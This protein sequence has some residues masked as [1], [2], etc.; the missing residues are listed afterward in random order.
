M[1][2]Q[3]NDGKAGRSRLQRI[4]VVLAGIIVGQSI[5]Y[6]PSLIG[7]K[8]LLPL[9]ILAQQDVYIPRTPEIA[10][11]EAQNPTLTDMVYV[12][13]PNRHFTWSELRAGR[14]PMWAP[15]Q[16]GGVP[17]IWPKFSPFLLLQSLTSSPV[18]LAWGQLLAALVAGVGA[19][20]FFSRVLKVSFWPAAFGAWCYPL[21]G[22]FVFWLG[23]PTSLPVCWLPWL[24]LAV[25]YVAHA[26]H[27]LAPL[28]L[29]IATGL[30]LVSGFPDVAGQVL[31]G[32]GLYGLLQCVGSDRDA[33]FNRKVPIALARLACGWALGFLLAAPYLLPVVDYS[34]TGSRM[35]KRGG[36]HEERP[37]IGLAVVPQVVLPDMYGAT[38][39][40]TIRI[41]TDH[42]AESTAA[43]YAGILTTLLLAPLAFCSRTHRRFNV[44]W[45]LLGLFAL[46]WCANVPGF[47]QLFRLPGLNMMSHNRLV[48]LAS[49]AIISLA[50]V[51]LDVLVQGAFEWRRWQWVPVGMAGLLFL[52]SLFRVLSLPEPLTVLLPKVILSGKS[53]S[54]VQDL[55]GMRQVQNWFIR[56][57]SLCAVWCGMALGGW[58]WL[59]K[60][61]NRQLRVALV[62]ATL[63]LVDLLWFGHARIVQCAPELYYPRIP[64]LEWVANSAPGRVMGYGCLP[65]TVSE[66]AGLNDIR[67]HDAV[68]PARMVELITTASDG[69]SGMPRYA[70]TMQVAPKALMSPTGEFRVSPIMDMLGLRYIIFRGAPATNVTPDFRGIDYWVMKNSAAI[71]RA[72]VPKRVEVVSDPKIR[73]QKMAAPSFNPREV[74]YVESAVTL[75]GM[76]IGK[77][78]ILEQSPTR[79]NVETQMETPGLVVLSDRWDKGWRADLDGKEAPI[80]IANHAIRG[81]VVPQGTHRIVFRYQPASFIWGIRMAVLALLIIVSWLVGWTVLKKVRRRAG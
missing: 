40:G 67:G 49:F 58:Y 8:V 1:T 54:W 46:T 28:G 22:F 33:G 77:S 9:D 4:L 80:L 32:S 20:L 66:M 81:V 75:P 13:E 70:T 19:Y 45:L 18:V 16:F 14:L 31:L 65:A 59:R 48:F 25:H 35:E 51:G 76:C 10:K 60:L 73:L 39:A 2:E 6:G 37:P 61:P 57:Y 34:R 12:Y 68:E 41:T 7:R 71:E 38:R 50:V 63:V 62:F 64:A 53:F 17:F 74:A 30:V 21:T 44:F 11:V 78:T 27:P 55:D 29:A 43:A 47:V 42:P 5:L 23:C 79:I 36:G 24:F 26:L 69:V 15:F 72:Y 56:Y 3:V 52:W